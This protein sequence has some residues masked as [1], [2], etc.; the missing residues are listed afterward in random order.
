MK[1]DE[2]SNKKQNF[3]AT[4]QGRSMAFDRHGGFVKESCRLSSQILAA[5][6]IGADGWSSEYASVD[7]L[8]R[9]LARKTRST[10][11]R[12]DYCRTLYML[13]RFT[14]KSPDELVKMPR[15][16]A[17]E[18]VQEFV[19]KRVRSGCS[20]GYG[21]NL[22]SWLDTFFR[23]NGFDGHRRLSLQKYHVPSR[24]RARPEYVPTAEEAFKMAN[25]AGSLRDRAIILVLTTTG[26]RNA[27]LRAVRYGIGCPDPMFSQYTIKNELRRKERN[28]AF[29]VYPE[30]KEYIPEACKN[31]FF[32]YTFCSAEATEAILDY[33]RE[34]EE[35][36]G[37]V[38]DDEPLFPSEHNQLPKELRPK[39]PL[40]GRQLSMIVKD[41]ARKAGLKHWKHVYA[42][43]LRKTFESILRNQ[44]SDLRLDIRD[45]EFLMGHKVGP[46]SQENYYDLS[47]VEEM[48]QKYA[49]M[50]FF[51]P[52]A[53]ER[54]K[55]PQKIIPEGEL[56][57]YL[58]EGWLFVPG[59]RLS[60]GKVIISKSP[61]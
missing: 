32:Y 3:L 19:D 21:N 14:G 22:L 58:A 42:H 49:R 7:K 34:R 13:C 45:Q 54:N 41:T 26:L 50:I 56:E 40:C 15:A 61:Y 5:L 24:Y 52:P 20:N 46:G 47:K 9:H 31:N 30:M 11:S 44:P 17:R 33:I 53:A 51:Q 38:E 18:V 25:V 48:R 12:F 16:K 1:T 6:K 37:Q 23:V 60:D 2:K 36:Y 10:S 27:T 8:L 55:S 39:T 29:V 28:T 35:K 57:K 59:S 43:T 4:P